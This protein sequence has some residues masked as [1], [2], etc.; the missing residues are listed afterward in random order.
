MYNRYSRFLRT[1]KI[2]QRGAI[3]TKQVLFWYI[4]LYLRNQVFPKRSKDWK[5][6]KTSHD[7]VIDLLFIYLFET[8]KSYTRE[9][10]LITGVKMLPKSIFLNKS[11]GVG[12]KILGL[13]IYKS[14]CCRNSKAL[15]K[16]KNFVCQMSIM[17]YMCCE[18]GKSWKTVEG[19][20]SDF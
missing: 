3:A 8:Q 9:Q 1:S 14:Y 7:C 16:P 10:L 11:I 6:Q 5:G 4:L 20:R 2:V 18:T 17:V 12:V 15:R 13:T 19:G